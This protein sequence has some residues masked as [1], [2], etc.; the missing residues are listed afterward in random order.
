MQFKDPSSADEV[1]VHVSFS[2]L[3]YLGSLS[4]FLLRGQ[5][6]PCRVVVVWCV[7]VTGARLERPWR[8]IYE[9][10]GGT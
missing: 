7:S 4:V 8:Y 2:S 1:S 9:L 6:E 3:F 10:L 5:Y